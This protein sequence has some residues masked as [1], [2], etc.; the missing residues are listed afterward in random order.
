[1]KEED[2]KIIGH[3]SSKTNIFWILDMRDAGRDTK[4]I[5]GYDQWVIKSLLNAKHC[6]GGYST[7]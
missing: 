1:M 7:E 4:L 3:I 2:C 5:F 6:P